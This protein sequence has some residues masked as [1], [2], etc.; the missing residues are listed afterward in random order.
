M[1]RYILGYSISGYPDDGGGTFFED[2]NDVSAMD[3]RV[4]ELLKTNKENFNIDFAVFVSRFYT[5]EPVN[6]TTEFKRIN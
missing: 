6:I 2:F 4:N 5:Y 1:K 3:Q